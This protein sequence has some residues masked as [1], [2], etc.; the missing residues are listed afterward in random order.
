MERKKAAAAPMALAAVIKSR[1]DDGTHLKMIKNG[2]RGPTTKRVDFANALVRET[3]N[4]GRYTMYLVHYAIPNQN[5]VVVFPNMVDV[6]KQVLRCDDYRDHASF[7]KELNA[8]L[9]DSIEHT[10]E[11]GYTKMAVCY[12]QHV[13]ICDGITGNAYIVWAEYV[14]KTNTNRVQNTPYSNVPLIVNTN[15]YGPIK[16]VFI[17]KSTITD[18][19]ELSRIPVVKTSPVLMMDKRY[20]IFVC[21]KRL[22]QRVV[23]PIE[24]KSRQEALQELTRLIRSE[25]P[26]TRTNHFSASVDVEEELPEFYEDN[27]E[28]GENA[29]EDP[30]GFKDL[31]ASSSSSSSAGGATA[32]VSTPPILPSDVDEGDD[33]FENSDEEEKQK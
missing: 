19:S 11:G 20:P 23:T 2:T 5:I 22:T 21:E 25:T 30:L 7:N 14:N 13:F 4:T 32:S 33:P 17:L 28:F 15:G 12:G 16:G 31:H 1:L 24:T 26:K 6:N 18:E 9:S 27:I 29:M 3:F 10:P 8:R